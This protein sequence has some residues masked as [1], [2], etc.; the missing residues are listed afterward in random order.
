MCS[1]VASAGMVT[2]CS[3]YNISLLTTLY[4]KR[5]QTGRFM[6][7]GWQIT[8][9]ELVKLCD[10]CLSCSAFSAAA[11]ETALINYETKSQTFG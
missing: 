2:N 9:S 4:S 8:V 5:L 11:Q 6:L 3:L 10:S 7:L 1:Q